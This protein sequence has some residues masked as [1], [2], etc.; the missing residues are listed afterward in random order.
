M[1]DDGRI[2][3]AVQARGRISL[4]LTQ[5]RLLRKKAAARRTSRGPCLRLRKRSSRVQGGAFSSL[6]FLG[7]EEKQKVAAR[8]HGAAVNN[9]PLRISCYHTHTHKKTL[10]TSG[11]ARIVHFSNL[12][13]CIGGGFQQVS[14]DPSSEQDPP[15]VS[16][17]PHPSSEDRS[18]SGASSGF[19]GLVLQNAAHF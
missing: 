18:S 4:T 6:R 9:F 8:A 1:R 12:M 15:S 7:N 3:E 19:S 2:F 13:G 17:A 10:P 16:A 11:H 5:R 14:A